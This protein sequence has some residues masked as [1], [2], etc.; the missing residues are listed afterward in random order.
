MPAAPGA[1]GMGLSLH[2]VQKAAEENARNGVKYSVFTTTIGYKKDFQPEQSQQFL[3]IRDHP[4]QV[5]ARPVEMA[6]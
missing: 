4:L 5:K 1:G 3:D 2:N 6:P